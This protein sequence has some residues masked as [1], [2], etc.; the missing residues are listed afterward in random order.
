[1]APALPRSLLGAMAKNAG[2]LGELLFQ[3][4]AY[5]FAEFENGR[6][7][8]R[9]EHL[10]PFLPPGE[11]MGVGE[12][13]QVPRHIGLRATG[14]LDQRVDVL[15]AGKQS[16]DE[17]QPHRLRE[18]GEAP[19]DELERVVIEGTSFSHGPHGTEP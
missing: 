14:L 17:F 11:D 15:F 12:G 3:A 9:V 16:M 8:D 19:R 2:L 18:Y 6:V 7:G 1:M 5:E 4:S 10:Q 13:L